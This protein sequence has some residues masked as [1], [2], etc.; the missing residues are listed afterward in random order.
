[1]FWC[2]G[3]HNTRKLFEKSISCLKLKHSTTSDLLKLIKSA[4]FCSFKKKKCAKFAQQG[5]K[6]T[7]TSRRQKADSGIFSRGSSPA[8]RLIPFIAGLQ[9]GK[10]TDDASDWKQ[11]SGEMSFC[12]RREW[13]RGEREAESLRWRTRREAALYAKQ[14]STTRAKICI[15]NSYEKRFSLSLNTSTLPA[16]PS[17]WIMQ[18]S[19][20]SVRYSRHQIHLR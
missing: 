16:I 18:M 19:T 17:E 15:L 20:G 3:F 1:M 4:F 8:R 2:F 9:S 10:S 6:A 13:M 5:E 7:E 14:T 12:L 11:M